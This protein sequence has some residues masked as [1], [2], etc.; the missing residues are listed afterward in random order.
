MERKDSGD[1]TKLSRRKFLATLGAL[2]AGM[3]LVP[4]ASACSQGTT[5][6][7]TA[8]PKT[9]GATPAPTVVQKA[10]AGSGEKV[11]IKL[12]H[13]HTVGSQVDNFAKKFAELVA[14]KTNGQAE[15]QIFPAA[16]LGQEAEAVEGIHLG[17]L[18]MTIG[19]SP[20]LDKYSREQGIEQLPFIFD[21]WDH[22]QRCMK[23]PVAAE[24]A[25]RLEQKSNVKA[26]GWMSI[27]WRHMLFRDKVVDTL[28]GMKGLKMRSPQTDIYVKMFEALG[29]KPTTITWGEAYTALQT[30]VVDGMETPLQSGI[31]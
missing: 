7:S 14:Q 24:L 22:A 8:V 21:D 26:L 9:S 11:V 27:G 25:K 29:S 6:A 3:A 5:P 23:G 2:G 18:Q 28:E 12:G 19:S 1:K 4:L 16:Q 20:F 10:A 30:G 17:T 31:D 13:H 15:V